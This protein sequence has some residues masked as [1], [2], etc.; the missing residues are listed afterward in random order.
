MVA[1]KKII[2]HLIPH[3]IIGLSFSLIHVSQN[4]IYFID[5]I[6]DFISFLDSLHFTT[7]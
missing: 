5:F 2:F 7:I 6:F 3:W 4:F 1:V